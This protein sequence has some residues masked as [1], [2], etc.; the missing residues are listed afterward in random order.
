LI[1][2][3]PVLDCMPLSP[4]G[5]TYAEHLKTVKKVSGSRTRHCGPK[6]IHYSLVQMWSKQ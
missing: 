6:A 2:K 5:E 1:T 3:G 4:K